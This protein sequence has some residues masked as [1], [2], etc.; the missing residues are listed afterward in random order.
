MKD[1]ASQTHDY[2]LLR[3][4][5]ELSFIM[6]WVENNPDLTKRFEK[7]YNEKWEGYVDY[8]VTRIKNEAQ[9]KELPESLISNSELIDQQ[10]ERDVGKMPEIF[11]LWEKI[12]RRAA[13]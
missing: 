6:K 9:E 12:H 7:H 11:Y 13:Q 2:Q 10:R 5:W 1:S 8:R 4:A 3:W